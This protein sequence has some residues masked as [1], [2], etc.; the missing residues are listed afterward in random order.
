M[1]WQRTIRHRVVFAVV[2]QLFWDGRISKEKAET[3]QYVFSAG[4]K[5]LG[6]RQLPRHQRLGGPSGSGHDF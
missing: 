1:E 6:R 4:R 5:R 3:R 2:S